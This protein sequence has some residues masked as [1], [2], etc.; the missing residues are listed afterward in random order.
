MKKFIIKNLKWAVLI[1]IGLGILALLSLFVYIAAQRDLTNLESVL[2]QVISLIIGCGVSFFVGQQSV[3]KAAK[4][5]VK[6]HAVKAFRRLLSLY[7]SL[8]RAAAVIE[9]ADS[10]ET[11]E[12]YQVILARL[13][14]IIAMQLITG[15]DALK[16]WNDIVEEL[17]DLEQ[18]DSPSNKQ[19]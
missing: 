7:Q 16:D 19:G 10:S 2:F 12:N 14:E 4:E 3:R 1:L 9:S 8:A 18:E 15:D 17:D 5:D 11:K 6:S 13:E